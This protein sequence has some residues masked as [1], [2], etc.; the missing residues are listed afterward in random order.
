[1]L[2]SDWYDQ[3]QT[4]IISWQALRSGKRSP[5]QASDYWQKTLALGDFLALSQLLLTE[6]GNQ[7]SGLGLQQA[8]LRWERLQPVPTLAAI[9]TLQTVIHDIWQDKR[10][11]I[12]DKLCY[13]KLMI[14]LQQ[15]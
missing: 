6:I 8:D 1:M 9:N 5:I 3:R 7:I 12:Q 14:A 13:D 15:H 2:D 4:W 10:Q 11:N